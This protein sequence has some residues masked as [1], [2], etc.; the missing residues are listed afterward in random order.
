MRERWPMLE[1]AVQEAIKLNAALIS[2]PFVKD[3]IVMSSRYN[4]IEFWDGLRKGHPV[5]LAEKPSQLL[6]ERSKSYY[7]NLVD[8]CR[9]VVWWGNKKGAYL[10]LNRLAPVEAQLAGH[11]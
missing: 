4:I 7:P 9:E 2:Q 6:I 5:P 1:A 3:D 11:Y 8:W 10:Y